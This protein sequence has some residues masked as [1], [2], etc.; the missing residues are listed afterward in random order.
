MTKVSAAF[1]ASGDRIAITKVIDSARSAAVSAFKY[2]NSCGGLGH[3]GFGGADS[4]CSD[5][6]SSCGDGISD[7]GDGISDCGDDNSACRNDNSACRDDNSACGDDNSA[8]R[9]DTSRL[10]GDNPAARFLKILSKT[11]KFADWTN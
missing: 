9:D 8:C 10:S 6:N 7:C 4:S 2:H 5:G 3:S 11:S 1:S